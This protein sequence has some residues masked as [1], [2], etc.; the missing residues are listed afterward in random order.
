MNTNQNITP[1]PGTDSPRKSN[2]S[3]LANRFSTRLLLQHGA[4]VHEFLSNIKDLLTL[5]APKFAA[6]TSGGRVV[7]LKDENLSRSQVASFALH[8]GIGL[9]LILVALAPGIPIPPARVTHDGPIF[10]PGAYILHQIFA[11]QS[12]NPGRK[13]GGGGERSL[14]APTAGQEPLSSRQQL[15]PPSVHTNLN[16]LMLIPPTVIGMDQSRTPNPNLNNWGI[17]DANALT[18]SDGHG[19]CSGIGN[20]NG[21]GDG[22]G[23]GP[24]AG[25]GYGTG[26]CGDGPGSGNGA[27]VRSPECA[28][29][30]RPEYSDQARLAKYQGSVLLNV[31]VL[32]NGKAGRIEILKGVGMGLDEKAME[33][34]R[35]WQFKPAIGRDGKPIA[36]VV[37]IEVVFQL[38]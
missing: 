31:V 37:P 36:A 27:A 5:R 32:A 35:T 24:G 20:N 12:L 7:W 28:Y 9:L 22:T 23:K 2:D 4:R 26:C 38:F 10:V 29:C 33:A 17:P 8:G 30:P 14:V 13:G 25:P 15:V 34:V 11:P 1:E 6:A 16:A 19:C 18:G 21:S 3:S